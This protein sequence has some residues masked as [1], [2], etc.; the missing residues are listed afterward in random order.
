MIWNKGCCGD[1]ICIEPQDWRINAPNLV[2]TL[3]AEAGFDVLE[4][5]ESVQAVSHLSIA[6]K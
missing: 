5:G 4:P 2:E 6:L 3:G 1:M